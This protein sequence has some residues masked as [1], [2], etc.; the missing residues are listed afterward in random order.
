MKKRKH[1]QQ[2]GDFTIFKVQSML[3]VVD[4]RQRSIIAISYAFHAKPSTMN[5][6]LSIIRPENCA[7]WHFAKK[8]VVLFSHPQIIFLTRKLN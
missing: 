7:V 3:P 1:K 2:A 4:H 6:F 5:M 8:A